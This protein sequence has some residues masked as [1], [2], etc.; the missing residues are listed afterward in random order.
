MSRWTRPAAIALALLA[1]VPAGAQPAPAPGAPPHS[2]NVVRVKLKAGSSAA[3]ES[4]EASTVRAWARA[5]IR[6]YWIA[7]QSPKDAKD[8]LYL[9]LFR[10]AD[11]MDRA[12]AAYNDALKQHAELPKLQQRLTELT[13]SSATT[14]TTRRDDVDR[15]PA[16]VDFATMRALRLTTFQVRP[17]HE[18]D[19]LNAIRTANPKD[20]SW[21]V[22]EAND[23]STFAL[24]NLKKTTTFDRR[25]GPAVPRTLR[26]FQDTSGKADTRVYV[27]RPA[28]SHV[29]QTFAA[30]N[31]QFWRPA[32]PAT[33]H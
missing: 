17:G 31:P 25:D 10:T 8:V 11:E 5:R 14:L 21:L 33:P 9:N 16:G 22:Y 26:R 29:S 32:P 7:L 2:L 13:D 18:G 12:T 4:L 23:S 20:G 6:V 30:A 27:V 1:S 3:Y 15:A 28:M 19:F 24:I